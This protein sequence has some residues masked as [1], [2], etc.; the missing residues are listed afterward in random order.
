[1]SNGTPSP[2][3]PDDAGGAF[4]PRRTR[5]R[6]GALLAGA[7]LVAAA[8]LVATGPAGAAKKP[9]APRAMVVNS[10]ADD[11]APPSGTVTLRSALA[12]IRPGGR[13]TFARALDG[14][15]IR[16]TQV[17]DEHTV[18]PGET[19]EAGR[20]R[21]LRRARLRPLGALRPTRA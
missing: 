19:F 18:L 17:A 1:M 4:S 15:T 20:V 12:R 7:L 14:G 9:K 3:R 16:L 13:I 5:S 10:L 6:P 11:A 8:A 21:R 2:L